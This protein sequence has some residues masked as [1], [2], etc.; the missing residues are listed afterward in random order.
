MSTQTRRELPARLHTLAAMASL[1]E[2]LEQT[3]ATATGASAE[4]YRGVARQVTSLLA[5]AEP[6]EHLHALLNA[7]PNTAELYENMR[8]DIAGLCRTP[9][10]AA[11]KAEMDAAALIK[12]LRT[13]KN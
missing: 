13:K 8:Y 9:L 7:A 5:L 11:L 1:L 12:R 3:P 2:R 10:Q 4:Q 6:D